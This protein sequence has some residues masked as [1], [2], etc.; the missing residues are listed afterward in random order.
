MSIN[1]VSHAEA[2]GAAA[3]NGEM[4]DIRHLSAEQLGQLG[5]S[6]IAY[7]KPVMLDG[8]VA[9]AIHAADGTPMAVAGDRDLAIAAV[10]Q[11]EMV[12]TLVH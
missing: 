10:R 11:H 2:S 1:T 8:A 3:Q 6:Q 5:V 4:I 9:F 12:P 7:V